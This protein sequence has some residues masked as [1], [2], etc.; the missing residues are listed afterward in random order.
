M[1]QMPR[2]GRRSIMRLTT[3]LALLLAV[4]VCAV[5]A[6]AGRAANDPLRLTLQRSDFPAKAT[7][8]AD[9]YP[10]VDKAMAAEGF[11]GKT[12]VYAGE[13]PLGAGRTLRVSGDV[14]VL[15]NVDNARRWFAR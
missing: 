15:A 2:D 3:T 7:W 11:Q 10:M 9:R 14:V 4:A 6:T 1:R 12:A 13:V 8:S 5:P